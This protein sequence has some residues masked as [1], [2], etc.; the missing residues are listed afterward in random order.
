[1]VIT[2]SNCEKIA[3][4]SVL[5][6]AYR[7]FS[8]GKVL[9]VT[10]VDIN[11]HIGSLYEGKIRVG[12]KIYT[13]CFAITYNGVIITDECFCA[14]IVSNGICEHYLAVFLYMKHKKNIIID[15]RVF[16]PSKII[17][18]S[19]ES[20]P[21]GVEKAVDTVIDRYIVNNSIS[22]WYLICAVEGLVFACMCAEATEKSFIERIKLYAVA[23]K[24]ADRLF[25]LSIEKYPRMLIN[26]SKQLVKIVNEFLME[27]LARQNTS[28]TQ[29]AFICLFD[30]TKE[31]KNWIIKYNI[32]GLLIN[33]CDNPALRVFLEKEI[34]QRIYRQKDSDKKSDLRIL[35]C[36]VL[37]AHSIKKASAYIENN[38]NDVSF[39]RMAIDLNMA[40]GQ[41]KEAKKLARE[42]LLQDKGN[43]KNTML[44]TE[45]L[46]DIGEH[47]QDTKT[48]RTYAKKMLLMGDFDYYIKYKSLFGKEEW[49]Y[50]LEK[51]VEYLRNNER[52]NEIYLQIIIEEDI[53][54]ELVRFC[55]NNPEKIATFY[56]YINT[57]NYNIIEKYL[58][59]YCLKLKKSDGKKEEI[60][61]QEIALEKIR[62]IVNI[63]K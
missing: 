4:K 39:R 12:R 60:G 5:E 20:S 27:N 16:S 61:L 40:N 49:D 58:E 44:W 19:A 1:M 14:G 25:S 31:I 62:G 11:E 50:I 24:K 2:I 38:L 53:Q 35:Y 8:H 3:E 47:C 23:L 9:S 26:H 41:Y 54:S 29:E 46:Y 13:L 10:N 6:K 57:D 30:I 52:L 42:G 36:M 43:N 48:M 32:F 51:L 28:D 33:F 22:N 18:S 59:E 17:F 63:Q 37:R 55:R 21:E 34:K 7:L 45:T 15:K 56:P